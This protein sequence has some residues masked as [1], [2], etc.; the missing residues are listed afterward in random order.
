MRY[1]C[2]VINNIRYLIPLLEISRVIKFIKGNVINTN[3][4]Q[5][6][7]VICK[8]INTEMNEQGK[9]GIITADKRL[10]IVDSVVSTIKDTELKKTEGCFGVTNFFIDAKGLM[11][12]L[13]ER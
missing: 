7:R 11:Y 2:Y 4:Y 13:V 12:Q 3:L 10:L 8:I 9:V 1:C 6:G 5:D